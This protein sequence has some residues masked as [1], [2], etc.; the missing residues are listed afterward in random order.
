MASLVL[1]VLLS[2]LRPSNDE[3]LLNLAL[4]KQLLKLMGKTLL[5][6]ACCRFLPLL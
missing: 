2:L 3:F 6:V 5:E 4:M 1:T